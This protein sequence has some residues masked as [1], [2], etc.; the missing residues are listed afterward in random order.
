VQ[1]GRGSY[2]I[3]QNSLNWTNGLPVGGG[4]L[5]LGGNLPIWRRLPAE[6]ATTDPVT[7]AG[8][9]ISNWLGEGARVVRDDARGFVIL[10][11]DGLRRFRM[12]FAGPG[13]PLHTHTSKCGTQ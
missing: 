10:S 12:D 9:G 6:V 7:Q 8:Q 13:T 11:R 3:Y 4:L 2:D 1:V 5:G